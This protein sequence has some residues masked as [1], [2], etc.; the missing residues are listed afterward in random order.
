[1]SKNEFLTELR[2]RLSGLPEADLEERV[3]FYAEIIE[4]K[5]EDGISEEEAVEGLGPIDEIVGQ[6]MSEIPLTKLVKEKVKQKKTLSPVW[7]VLLIL[8][9]PLWLALLLTFFAVILSVYVT[10]WSLVL[11]VYAVELSLGI[12]AIA[13]IVLSLFV[14]ITGEPLHALFFLGAALI[15]AALTILF[16]MVC[17]GMTK[18]MA[19]I[20]K[21]IILGIKY[22]FVGKE[23]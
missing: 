17:V 7:I 11:A 10:I 15:L 12:G 23:K 21:K 18:G 6:I 14:L 2:N 22:M 3:S 8:G 4:D 5:T 16:F 13:S 20:S 19:F 1:M 9:A